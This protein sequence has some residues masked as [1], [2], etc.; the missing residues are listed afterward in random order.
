MTTTPEDLDEAV[1]NWFHPPSPCEAI[2]PEDLGPLFNRI[3]AAYCAERAAHA[4]TRRERDRLQRIADENYTDLLDQMDEVWGTLAH[5]PSKV[6][7]VEVQVF[8]ET[9]RVHTPT[10]RLRA[11]VGVLEAALRGLLTGNPACEK[12][13]EKELYGEV[14]RIAW[15][16]KI[17]AAWAALTPGGTEAA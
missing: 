12:Y 14:Y 3:Y 17:D 5:G 13:E 16:R 6:G 9:R 8:L 4:T 2:Y 10:T 15:N 1:K 11:R 7:R